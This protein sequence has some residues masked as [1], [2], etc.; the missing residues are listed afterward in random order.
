M[1]DNQDLVRRVCRAYDFHGAYGHEWIDVPYGKVIRDRKNPSVWMANLVYDVTAETSSECADLFSAVDDAFSGYGFRH[2]ITDPRTP[3]S[4]A[5][6]LALLRYEARTPILQQVLTGKLTG[7]FVEVAMQPVSSDA[8]WNA[9]HHLVRIDHTEGGRTRGYDIDEDVTRGIV[10][11]Y[12]KKEDV[13]RFFLAHVD[14]SPVA[15]GS[16]VICPDGIGMVEDLFTR[17]EYRRRGVASS[18]IKHCVEDTRSR[19]AGP[20]FIGAF[21]DDQ[22]KHLYNQLG[23]EPL[24]LT[25]PYF[26]IVGDE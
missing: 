1:G 18:V 17:P 22:P 21:V 25:Q 7:E 20:V 19:G 5:A 6:R 10:E 16:G 2:F 24:C 9:L 23:F 12:R 14:G 11:G 3:P 13:C 4:F 26:K 8:D 15:Y